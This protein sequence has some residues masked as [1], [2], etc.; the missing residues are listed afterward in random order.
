MET[1][2]RSLVALVLL[3]PF[4]AGKYMLFYIYSHNGHTLS[5]FCFILIYKFI[6]LF[7]TFIFSVL[8]EDKALSMQ[9]VLMCH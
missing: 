4:L 2:L 5:M 1:N 7:L 6:C 3:V 8:D 9:S